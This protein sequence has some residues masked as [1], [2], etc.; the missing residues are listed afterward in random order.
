M[1]LIKLVGGKA[2]TMHDAC[3]DV[4]VVTTPI[5]PTSALFFFFFLSN[6]IPSPN[7]SYP[8]R[9]SSQ[10]VGCEWSGSGGL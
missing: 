9:C 6:I 7:A 5:I 8:T 10:Q 2:T 1:L 4:L 3:M